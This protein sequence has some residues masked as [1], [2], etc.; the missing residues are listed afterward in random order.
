[1]GDVDGDISRSSD[2][3]G[4]SIADCLLVWA[5]DLRVVRVTLGCTMEMYYV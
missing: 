1:M 3:D 4:R 5:V 2:G